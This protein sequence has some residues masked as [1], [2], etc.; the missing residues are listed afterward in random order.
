MYSYLG[1]HFKKHGQMC[2]TVTY[3]IFVTLNFSIKHKV[4]TFLTVAE[5]DIM[6]RVITQTR[7]QA[8]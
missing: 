1:N 3:K 6:G 8:F 2:E 7:G 5:C 4:L